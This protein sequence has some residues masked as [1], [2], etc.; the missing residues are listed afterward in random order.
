MMKKTLFLLL[1]AALALGASAQSKIDWNRLDTLIGTNRYATAYPLAQ[2][3]YRQQLASGSGIEQLTA[4]LYLNTL[5]YAYNSHSTDSSIMRWSHLARR[6]QGVDRA[7]AYAFLFQSYSEVFTQYYYWNKSTKPSD[8]PK[9]P[10]TSW[11][12]QRMEDTL[13]MCA[14]SVLAYAEALRRADPE[15]YIR[16]FAADSNAPFTLNNTLLNIAVQTLMDAIAKFHSGEMTL[17]STFEPLPL[18]VARVEQAD[19][20]PPF[21]QSLYYRIAR[22]YVGRS[23]DEACWIDLQRFAPYQNFDRTY[24]YYLPLLKTDE[25]KALLMM[26]R[27]KAF[28]FADSLVAAENACLEVEQQ[29]PHTYGTDQCRVLRREI[30]RPQFS[31]EHANVASSKRNRLALVKACNTR[32]L[33]FRLV[34]YIP[35]GPVSRDSLMSLTPIKEWQQELPDPG[36]HRSHPYLVPLPAVEQGTYRLLAYTD[37]VFSQSLYKSSDAVFINHN[38]PS[39]GRTNIMGYLVDRQSGQPLADKRVTL[40]S[41]GMSGHQRS[42]HTY[43]D[44]QGHYSFSTSPLGRKLLDPDRLTSV[45]DG[46]QFTTEVWGWDFEFS[47]N[48]KERLEIIM[49]DRPIYRLGDTVQFCC[50]AY[51]DR[52]TGKD[53]IRHKKPAAGVHLMATFGNYESQDTLYLTTDKHGRCWGQFVI[54]HEGRNGRYQLDVRSK[55]KHRYNGYRYIPVEAYKPPHFFVTLS[56]NKEG[57]DSGSLHRF[58]QPVTVY[59]TV[60]SF[61]GAP[62]DGAEGSWEVS[63]SR[64]EA[65]YL[66]EKNT[67]HDSLRVGPDGCFQFSFTPRLEDFGEAA[68]SQ[69]KKGRKATFVYEATVHVTDAD[70]EMQFASLGFHVSE[71]DGYC[72]L[73]SDD[74]TQL[75]FAYNDFDHHPLA[76][77][78][79]VELHQLRQPDT[80]R[81]LDPLMKE[82]PTAQWVGSKEEFHRLFPF[83]AYDSVEGDCHHWPV[84]AKWLD[85]TTDSRTLDIGPLPSGLY[86]ITFSTPDGNRHDTIVNYVA[87]TGSVTG[88]DLVFVRTRPLPN[89]ANGIHCHKGDTVLFELG[90]PYGNQPLYYHVSVASRVIKTGMIT[91]DSSHL[92]HLTIPIQKDYKAGLQI[93]FSA[94][95][96]GVIFDRSYYVHVLQPNQHLKIATTT[97]RDRTQPGQHERIAFRVSGAD[98]TGL[99]ANVCLTLFDS[100]LNQYR[101]LNYGLSLYYPTPISR[102]RTEGSFSLLAHVTNFHLEAQAQLAKPQLGFGLYNPKNYYRLISS[103]T[104]HQRLRGYVYDQKTGEVIPF[105][106]VTATY[107]G[108]RIAST[109]TDLDG[110]FSFASLP[111][112]ECIISIS[113]VGYITSGVQVTITSTPKVVEL[114]IQPS[115]IALQE[116]QIAD[117]KIPTIDIGA[118]ESGARLSADDIAY[119]P[120]TSVESIVASVGGVG[121]SDGRKRTSV[122]VPKEAIAEVMVPP[123]FT[124]R[125]AP[126]P[127]NLRQNLS[128]LAFFAPALRTD[129]Q[130]EVSVE[131]TL[132]DALTRWQLAAFAWTDQMQ[133]G[134]IERSIL[135]QK[136]LM[137]QPLLPRFLRQGDRMVLPAKVSNLSDSSL[138]V[139]VGFEI[140]DADTTHHSR[141][142]R[143]DTTL[144]LQPHSSVT[145]GTRL[146]VDEQWNAAQYKVFA[147]QTDPSGNHL[148]DGEQGLLPVLS[149]RQRVTST[150]LLYLPGGSESQPAM[151]S[152]SIPLN[153]NGTDSLTMAYSANPADYAFQALPHFKRHLMPGNIYLANSVYV[154]QLATLVDSLTP[155]QRQQAQRRNQ[156]DLRDLLQSRQHSK[157]GWSWMPQGKQASRYVTE[158]VLQRLALCTE[159][160][161]ERYNKQAFK[162]AL[163][164]IDRQVVEAYQHRT[165]NKDYAS[166]LSL[167]YTRSLYLPA[168]PIDSTD[169]LTRQAYDFYYQLY[170]MHADADMPLHVRGQMALLMQRMG[171]TADAVRQAIRIKEA[172]HTDE[173]KGM[174]WTENRYGYGW[175]QRPIETAALMVDVFADVLHD[176]TSVGRIQQ[177]IVASKQGTVWSSDMATASAVRALLRQPQGLA[178]PAGGRV[179][180]LVNGTPFPLHSQPEPIKVTPETQELHLNSQFSNLKSQISIQLISTS[181][182]PSWGALFHSRLLPLDSIEADSS[183]IALRKS[184]SRV[185][186]DGSLHLLTP[187]DTLRIGQRVRIRIDIT[188]LHD[189]DNLVLAEPRAAGLE[190]VSTAS[191]WR[192][193]QGLSYYVDVR[194]EGLNCYIDHLGEGKYYVEYDLYVRHAGTFSS[195][196]CVLRSVY[197][198]QFSANT[199]SPTLSIKD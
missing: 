183:G 113:S 120:G 180:A 97:F 166:S 186:S 154:N 2:Q 100:A 187:D 18:F 44:N 146:W 95:R 105:A 28:Y 49:T 31:I 189:I 38:T 94:V 104:Q 54:P 74:L 193:N 199:T 77:K 16:L 51:T 158:A 135:A 6:L 30:C 143:H 43:T 178:K 175:Y 133:T 93:M 82:N 53:Y 147:V 155:Q 32:L 123:T 45:T 91:L 11:H 108:V 106:N 85:R 99:A 118:P 68:E 134:S 17:Y 13:T 19:T 15:P 151:R 61:S 7:V 70:G 174:Y 21:P 150:T 159:R 27:A 76:G 117:C 165:E 149:N 162:R 148:S 3:A 179:D 52:A 90:S 87:P 163:K 181:P 130:G 198:P 50:L 48:Q 101:R 58:G 157:G 125:E 110:C 10:M 14:D 197:A 128:T 47:K 60:S 80:L 188:C 8:D 176:W 107:Q 145:V 121:Y 152:Y 59:G 26:K 41:Y 71:A 64:L 33:H 96:E 115:A 75:R 116:I 194:D 196:P 173:N 140:A 119:M 69:H 153:L 84:A 102:Q 185:A 89:W 98:S 92:T 83:S 24:H 79:R 132:P 73:V 131:F 29:F 25:M 192:W 177:W 190:P 65:A 144:T 57:A 4:A 9:L 156:R 62:M 124:S 22:C 23:A 63:C 40:H 164:Y 182:L 88:T 170:R 122:N 12:H 138:T 34:P 171:D 67:S 36:D 78:V 37:S 109:Q 161:E 1:L 46:D 112:G 139:Q 169:T 72:Q 42:R 137:V 129:E 172:A 195:G 160:K 20:M 81:T 126:V 142:H 103:H 111:E 141:R 184:M 191:G 66:R 86:R 39:K 35:E 168:F 167:L 136:E 55:G 56:P 114:T 5:D 127:E